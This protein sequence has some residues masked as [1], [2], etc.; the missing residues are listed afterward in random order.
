MRPHE[1]GRA[2]MQKDKMVSDHSGTSYAS[3]QDH[4]W[5]ALRPAIPRVLVSNSCRT[6]E[7]RYGP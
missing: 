6:D 5:P 2:G 1:A 7:E 4:R 3:V